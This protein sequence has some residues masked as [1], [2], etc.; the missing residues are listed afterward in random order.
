V[1]T[2]ARLLLQGVIERST[3]FIRRYETVYNQQSCD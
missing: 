1:H 3:D 2:V